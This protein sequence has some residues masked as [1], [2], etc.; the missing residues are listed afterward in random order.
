MGRQTIPNPVWRGQD[1]FI[2]GGGPSLKDFNWNLLRGLNTIGCNDAYL[3]GIGIC[4][5]CIFGDVKWWE[6]H[7][8]RLS[9]Y[10]GT[11]FCACPEVKKAMTPDWLYHVKQYASGLME[12]GVAWNGNTGAA[13]INLAVLL[14]AV[15]IFLLGFDMKRTKENSNWHSNNLDD[16]GPAI[17]KKF[18]EWFPFLIRDWK[19]KFSHVEIINVTDD[20]DLE[21]MPKI[22]VKEFWDNY[23]ARKIAI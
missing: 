12:D 3:L 22:G 23:H 6:K 1:V 4:R 13:A 21:G 10:Q 20:S 7:K 14:G 11:V 18:L 5:V 15:K 2:I 9:K 19:K 8:E 17:Y 16:N